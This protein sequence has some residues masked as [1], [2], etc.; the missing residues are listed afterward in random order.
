MPPLR[1]AILRWRRA[2]AVLISIGLA[3]N[4]SAQPI[5]AIELQPVFPELKVAYPDRLEEAPDGSGR[6]F[7]VE[8][9]GRILVVP[10]G[11]SGADPKV[12]L[13]ITSRNPH[14]SYEQGLLGFAF[15]PQ[16]KTNGLCYI[17][18]S[19]QKPWRSIVSEFK[20]S[21]EDSNRA[22]LKSERIL[23][24]VPQ[25]T[26]VH[27]AGQ[28]SFGP[29]GFLYVSLGDG[30]GQ[31]DPFNAGQNTSTLC[32]KI[33]R[34]DVN[35]RSTIGLAGNQTRLEYGIPTGNPFVGEPEMFE[36]GVRKEIWAY[37]FRNPW[38]FSW[39][40]ATGQMWA[41]DVGQDQWE[42]VNLVVKGGNYGWCA[43]EGAHRF[44]PGPPGAQYIDPV[45][46]FAH[47]PKFA[48]AGKFPE[49]GIGMSVVGGYVYRGK[50]YPALQG[51]YLYADYV[52]GTFFGFRFKDG[53]VAEHAT[54]LRQPKN[55]TSFAEDAEGELYA[56]TYEG[57][58]FAIT[59]PGG[60]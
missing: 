60:K 26:E 8:Q 38:R 5:P 59:V 42:E 17:F 19:Q 2:G 27:K 25:P 40:R 54:L 15:H 20:V 28:V 35:S 47:N 18:Y 4:T 48:S 9:D 52:L 3:W 1:T 45:I 49:H 14:D 16:F 34:I 12:F 39:D 50:K 55:I 10:K 58:I 56:L 37:G 24:D 30:G 33:L 6:F 57:G 41:G 29:D 31:N 11:D 53:K 44:K 22:D 23:L 13:D 32:G 36:N 46:E 21:L 43:R 7:I 51:V